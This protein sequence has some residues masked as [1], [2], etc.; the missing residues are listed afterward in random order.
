MALT[1][2]RGIEAYKSTEIGTANQGKLIVM[3][4]DGAIRFLGIAMDHMEP[5]SYDTVNNNIVKAQ[6][7]ITELML[8]L[9]M[10]DGG[11]IAQNLFN[12]YAYLKKR[13]LEA[14]MQKDSTILGEVVKLMSELRE[15]WDEIAEKEVAPV[16]NSFATMREQG[17]SFSIQG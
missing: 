17:A 7:I 11:E 5:R 16:N 9:N 13:L 1:K 4:Y 12:I 8:S 10:E 14:N 6:D 2:Q 15:A 3:L